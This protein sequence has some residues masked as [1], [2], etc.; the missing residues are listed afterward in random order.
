MLPA[1]PMAAASLAGVGAGS[2][3]LAPD[4]AAAGIRSAPG[5][6][7]DLAAWGRVGAYVKWSRVSDR[8]S[9]TRAA[10]RAFLARFELEVDPHLE[11]PQLIRAQRAEAARRAYFVRLGIASAR[12]R[13]LGSRP[14][15]ASPPS[16]TYRSFGSRLALPGDLQPI[17]GRQLPVGGARPLLGG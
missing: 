15:P 5:P 8:G 11:L 1:G 7:L 16:G 6:S 12:R 9:A 14:E 13:R 10:R 3:R 4:S 17:T 2:P